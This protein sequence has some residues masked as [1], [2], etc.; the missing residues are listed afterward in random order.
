MIIDVFALLCGFAVAAF[1]ATAG[2]NTAWVRWL[3][4]FV[5]AA[6]SINPAVL[7]LPWQPL[8]GF[9]ASQFAM[10]ILL[11]ACLVMNNYRRAAIP[12][13]MAGVLSVIWISALT[14]QGLPLPAAFLFVIAISLV[15]IW[16]SLHRRGFAGRLLED[17][18]NILV[19]CFTLALIIIPG[20][21]SGW[22]SAVILQDREDTLSIY[23]DRLPIVLS[24]S[25]LFCVMGALFAMRKYR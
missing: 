7:A 4:G 21:L 2:D 18:A 14:L 13:F 12:L 17:E 5:L 25:A 24:I 15:C 16:A 3:A 20:T 11:V 19:L 10:L 8:I 9:D 22:E 6:M 23:R 1:A